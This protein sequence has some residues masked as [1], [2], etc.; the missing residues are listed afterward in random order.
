LNPQTATLIA[1]LIAAPF[2]GSFLGT[3]IVR[4]PEGKP[5]ALG[6]SACPHCG[7]VLAPYELVPFASWIAQR[8]RCRSCGARVSLFYPGIELAA[9]GIAGW[10]ATVTQGAPFLFSCVLGWILLV[11]AVTDVRTLRLLDVMVIALAIAGLAATFV[12]SPA[13]LTDH[14]IGGAVGLAALAG[15][16]WLYRALRGRDGLG[17]GDAKLFGAA[18]LW[19]GW[20]GL[21]SLLV[22][23]SFGGLIAALA[24]LVR[25]RS[26]RA[27]TRIPFGPFLALGLW[28][29]WLYGPLE[30]ALNGLFS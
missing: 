18:G 27:D 29:V 21:P 25:N 11:L 10:A 30:F 6:R 8:G 5:V 9:L 17:F 23:A 1:T 26:L 15:L 24:L 20:Q 7:H 16:A 22:I 4:L 14:L 3:L 28:T 2:I 19:I 13:S 12:L